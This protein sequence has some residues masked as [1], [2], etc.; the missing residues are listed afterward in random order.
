MRQLLNMVRHENQSIFFWLFIIFIIFIRVSNLKLI[1]VSYV[2][3][4]LS[5][6]SNVLVQHSVS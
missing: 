6:A 3:C 2:G 5:V 4:M 1:F